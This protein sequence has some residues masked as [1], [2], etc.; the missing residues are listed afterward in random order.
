MNRHRS[1]CWWKE[2]EKTQD[3]GLTVHFMCQHGWAT[4][5]LDIWSE[6]GCD[7][8]V[9]VF[10]TE[11]NVWVSRWSEAA[12]SPWCGWD[13]SALLT[14][15]EQKGRVR[16]KPP[17]LTGSEL[18]HRC[19]PAF[20]LTLN[21]NLGPSWVWNLL[22]VRWEC[23]RS[24]LLILGLHSWTGTTLLGLLADLRS[25]KCSAS[26]LVQASSP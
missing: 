5:C 23:A 1:W 26:I 25:W 15:W 13:W 2:L 6:L 18:G 7:A 12:C 17:C 19:A 4:G 11:T 8:F 14:P 21:W 10:V 9:R 3:T 22:N 16:E 24:A 20:K